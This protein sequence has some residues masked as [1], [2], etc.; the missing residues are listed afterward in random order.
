[1]KF[2]HHWAQRG[3]YDASGS[4]FPPRKFRVACLAPPTF[5]P[6]SDR[7]GDQLGFVCATK[8]TPRRLYYGKSSDPPNSSVG[9]GE[10]EPDTP[11]KFR[12]HWA[13]RG[14]YDAS[15]STYPPRKFREACLSHPTFARNES[16]MSLQVACSLRPLQGRGNGDLPSEWLY[17][18]SLSHG[19]A[20]R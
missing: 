2:R 1:M 6:I 16:S 19:R 12:R 9:I 14:A 15:G 18:C 8:S 5:W 4:T 20:V 11:P 10:N 17:S 3:A 7:R 13:Q